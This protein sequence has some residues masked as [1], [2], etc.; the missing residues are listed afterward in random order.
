MV[1][2][3]I[4]AGKEAAAVVRRYFTEALK[5]VATGIAFA[6]RHGLSLWGICWDRKAKAWGGGAEDAGAA[7]FAERVHCMPH[8]HAK[9]SRPRGTARPGANAGGTAGPFHW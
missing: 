8:R 6:D 2:V 5:L 1:Y 9:P 4:E 7:A 3:P